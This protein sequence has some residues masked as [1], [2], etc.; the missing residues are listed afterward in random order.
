MRKFNYNYK[1]GNT[2]L[3]KCLDIFSNLQA[4]RF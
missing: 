4:V 3:I 2:V 1:I